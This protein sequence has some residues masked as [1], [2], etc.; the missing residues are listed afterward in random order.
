MWIDDLNFY[1]II[2]VAIVL[3]CLFQGYLGKILQ[4]TANFLFSPTALEY[5]VIVL[6]LCLILYL[7]I[8]EVHAEDI[9]KPEVKVADNTINIHNPNISV[10]AD[11][12][13]KGLTNVGVGAA[14]AGGMSAMAALM[15]SSPLP[16]AIKVGTVIAGGAAAGVLVTATNAANSIAQNKINSKTPTTGVT[17]SATSSTPTGT[18]SSDDPT[19][20]SIDSIGNNFKDSSVMDLLSSNCYL[21]IIILYLLFNLTLL[22][23]SDLIIKYNWK[24]LFIK[25]IF[26]ERFYNLVMKTINYSSK[27]NKIWIWLI[28]VLL[29]ISSIGSLSISYFILNNIDTIS[30]IIQQFK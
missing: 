23:L 29:V 1:I 18:P 10:P 24:F 27:V 6:I 14:I 25:N 26:G 8:K 5:L 21:H 13:A 2:S 7:T 22:L 3:F 12:V 9:P 28:L 4:N 20:F 30:G 19:A 11:A 15:K 16:P 17:T